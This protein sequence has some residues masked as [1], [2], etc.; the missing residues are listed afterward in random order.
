MNK[1]VCPYCVRSQIHAR[2]HKKRDP[3]R[4]RELKYTLCLPHRVLSWLSSNAYHGGNVGIR[5]PISTSKYQVEAVEIPIPESEENF[6][7]AYTNI[8]ES[9]P[10]HQKYLG[11][12]LYQFY[13]EPP[14]FKFSVIAKGDIY[15]VRYPHTNTKKRE[16]IL[17]FRPSVIADVVE[18]EYEN[19]RFAI[20]FGVWEEEKED[21]EWGMLES[22][23]SNF[24]HYIGYNS[25]TP[26]KDTCVWGKANPNPKPSSDIKYFSQRKS[27]EECR[28]GEDGG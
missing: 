8:E 19:R 26:M 23:I 10:H 17:L 4:K 14:Q 9:K 22:N 24:F 28:G 15:I 12:L 13:S 11:G 27:C 1:E 16:E 21:Y 25:L 3:Q 2:R 18:G 20:I 6:L 7:Y 5:N